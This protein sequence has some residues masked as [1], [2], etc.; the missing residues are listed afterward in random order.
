VRWGIFWSYLVIVY[1]FNEAL[2]RSNT[3][4]FA[5]GLEP[6]RGKILLRQAVDQEVYVIVGID[7]QA[8]SQEGISDD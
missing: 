5:D 3:P 1:A 4:R 6:E 8:Y 7:R 2:F